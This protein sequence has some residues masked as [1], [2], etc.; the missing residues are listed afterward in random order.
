MVTP[1]AVTWSVDESITGKQLIS[2]ESQASLFVDE[3]NAELVQRC[4]T[5]DIHGNDAADSSYHYKRSRLSSVPPVM[6]RKGDITLLYRPI[7]S[8]VGPRMPSMF[9]QTVTQDLCSRL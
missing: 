8:I 7:L 5:H 1:K 6:Y 3:K 9:L 2:G 4:D